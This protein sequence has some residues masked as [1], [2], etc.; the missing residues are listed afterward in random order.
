FDIS[1]ACFLFCR[2][3][4]LNLMFTEGFRLSDLKSRDKI[5]Q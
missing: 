5:C 2:S 1:D 4:M 3:F